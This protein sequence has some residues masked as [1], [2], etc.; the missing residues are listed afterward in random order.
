[1]T[2]YNGLYRLPSAL[3]L[4]AKAFERTRLHRLVE[5]W[6]GPETA[7]QLSELLADTDGADEGIAQAG[8]LSR[9][10]DRARA[11]PDP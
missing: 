3:R 2:V 11:R 5:R 4:L 8:G 1:M 9:E 6:L 10:S 7:A